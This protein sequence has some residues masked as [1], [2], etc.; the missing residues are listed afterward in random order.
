MCKYFEGLFKILLSI[1]FRDGDEDPGQL[2]IFH[3]SVS[4][5]RTWLGNKYLQVTTKQ[6]EKTDFKII[7]HLK[8]DEQWDFKTFRYILR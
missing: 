2:F 1:A 4:C 6:G 3:I 7:R 5:W 8:T